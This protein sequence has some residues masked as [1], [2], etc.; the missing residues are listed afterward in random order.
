MDKVK[1][2]KKYFCINYVKSMNKINDQSVRTLV[3]SKIKLFL[4]DIT[5]VNL[6]KIISRVKKVYV[7]F[8]GIE[9]DKI[10]AVIYSVSAISS[11]TEI[12]I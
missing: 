7:L 3:Y 5:D 2:T 11:L 8:K 9:M 12:Q 1:M 10:Q 6:H 4:F